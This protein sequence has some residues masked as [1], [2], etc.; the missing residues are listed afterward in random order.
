MTR[1]RSE[2]A[3]T[4]ALSERCV[5]GV[6]TRAVAAMTAQVCGVE[7]TSPQVRRVATQL[8]AALEQGRTC[9]L[10]ICRYLWL[11]ARDEKVR[12]DGQAHDA[13][14]L[15]TM[16]LQD[17]GKRAIF[18]RRSQRYSMPH[19]MPG[20]DILAC[21]RSSRSV[22]NIFRRCLCWTMTCWNQLPLTHV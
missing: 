19:W 4:L 16:G 9:F 7:L 2:R 17:D 20:T 15:I 5:Q 3:L 14:E 6:S 11:D 22:Y 21:L 10:A 12:S 1:L 8:D 18:C 13:A